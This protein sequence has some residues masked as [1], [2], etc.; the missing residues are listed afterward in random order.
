MF[1][2]HR[3]CLGST[4]KRYLYLNSTN[5]PPDENYLLREIK[6]QFRLFKGGRVALRKDE[7]SGI[8]YI[9]IDHS[10][11][12]NAISGKKNPIANINVSA[13]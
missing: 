11:R 10:E 1:S 6:D 2:L 13:G 5:R 3:L 7:N 12:K 8:A 4:V 9:T